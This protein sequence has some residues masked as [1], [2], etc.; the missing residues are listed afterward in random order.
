MLCVVPRDN[1][2]VHASR[3]HVRL[4]QVISNA[5]IRMCIQIYADGYMQLDTHMY[6]TNLSR[7]LLEMADRPVEVVENGK[8]VLPGDQVVHASALDAAQ[9]IRVGT[10]LSEK[11]SGLVASRSGAVKVLSGKAGD[12]RVWVDGNARRYS[13]C[14][15]VFCLL[16]VWTGTDVEGRLE[17]ACIHAYL[18]RCTDIHMRA[19]TF[20]LHK[21]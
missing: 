18:Y 5:Y 13:P 8:I 20:P 21:P 19:C 2:R 12:V 1:T 7:E 11:G 6:S 15:Q 16:W 9:L 10:G 4:S 3:R 17:I 14:V